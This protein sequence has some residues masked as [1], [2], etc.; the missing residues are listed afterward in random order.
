MKA[1]C[2]QQFK[3][4]YKGAILYDSIENI[5]GKGENDS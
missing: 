5:V 4:G 3:Y 1:F 2:R